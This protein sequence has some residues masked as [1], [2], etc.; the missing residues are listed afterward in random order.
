MRKKNYKFL[1]ILILSFLIPLFIIYLKCDSRTFES[2]VWGF[3]ISTFVMIGGF[4]SLRFTFNRP[5]NLFLGA[6]VGGIF[7]RIVFIL[8]S[9]FYVLRFSNLLIKE[10][11]MSLL[12]YY[13]FLQFI[14]VMYFNRILKKV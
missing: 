7:L 10:Y 11:F 4:L 1:L 8:L 6:L 12:G 2:V 3:I 13:F 5:I 9:G 14:E